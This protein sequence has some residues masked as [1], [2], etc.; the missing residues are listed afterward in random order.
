MQNWR[1]YRNFR[2]YR[3]ADDSYT[4]TI[5]V[6]GTRLEV[7]E[8]IYAAYAEI[9]YKMEN[10]EI[11][12]KHDR[13]LKDSEGKAVRDEYGQPIILPE[14]EVSLEKLIDEDWEYQSF[15][16]SPEETIVKLL[17]VVE[18]RVCLS[19]LGAEERELINALFFNG[20]TI[21]EYAEITGRSKSSIDRHKVKILGKLRK[22]LAD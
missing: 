11:G 10:M 15:E 2:R 19:L 5:T 6:D 17:G 13:V 22:L 16:P 1:S 12:L 3:N 9:G 8:E 18:L 21:R 7:S 14:R 20:L 4:C